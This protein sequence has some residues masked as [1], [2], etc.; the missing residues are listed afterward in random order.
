MTLKAKLKN[1]LRIKHIQI[2]SDAKFDIFRS[3]EARLKIEGGGGGGQG[4]KR[5][6][7][8]MVK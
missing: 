8:D 4:T 5:L 7:P 6:K 1:N 2:V 3:K